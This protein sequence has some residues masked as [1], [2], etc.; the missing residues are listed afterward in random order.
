MDR[1]L[2]KIILKTFYSENILNND[3]KMTKD[4]VY[5]ILDNPSFGAALS[6]IKSLPMNDST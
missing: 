4:G 1:R 5:K 2:I 6:Y 3:F